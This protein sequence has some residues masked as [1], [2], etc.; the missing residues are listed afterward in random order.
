MFSQ[1][2]AVIHEYLKIKNIRRKFCG[3]RQTRNEN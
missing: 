1:K 3:K 2:V